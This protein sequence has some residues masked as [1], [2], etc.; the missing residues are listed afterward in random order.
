MNWVLY[1]SP[2]KKQLRSKLFRQS[3]EQK[4]N[5]LEYL[6]S[7]AR[8]HQFPKSVNN[9]YHHV[10]NGRND[11][12]RVINF[13]GPKTMVYPFHKPLGLR[14]LV[15]R[16]LLTQQPYSVNWGAN[17]SGKAVSKRQTT[18]SILPHLCWSNQ[19][20]KTAV[21]HRK[22][23]SNWCWPVFKICEQCFIV[24]PKVAMTK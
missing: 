4:T 20:W 15:P 5:N 7:C 21:K 18:W 22:C 9:A 13:I 1:P 10:T 6:T 14:T 8:I 19:V 3:S 11:Q 12:R 23:L 2:F 16:L 17:Y 24:S